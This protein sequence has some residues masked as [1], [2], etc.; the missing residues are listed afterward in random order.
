MRVDIYRTDRY[1]LS[2]LIYRRHTPCFGSVVRSRTVSRVTDSIQCRTVGRAT[3]CRTVGGATR[4]DAALS[5]GR[6]NP[7]PHCR[8]GDSTRCGTI[9][10]AVPRR[11]L[12]RPDPM[13]HCRH[14]CSYIRRR[15]VPS[16]SD[17]APSARVFL[18][19]RLVRPDPVR[20]GCSF[21][22]PSTVPMLRLH[23]QPGTRSADWSCMYESPAAVVGAAAIAGRM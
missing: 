16:R 11:G 6:F 2:C 14:G 21:I 5:V 19:R 1:R 9:G 10:T 7:M 12:V 15:L 8:W 18:R 3:R 13:R 4:S 17:A 23:T 20:H 22:R